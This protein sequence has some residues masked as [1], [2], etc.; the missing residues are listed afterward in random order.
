MFGG[1]ILVSEAEEFENDAAYEGHLAHLRSQLVEAK[2]S[3]LTGE[4]SEGVFR[5][6]VR[7][8]QKRMRELGVEIQVG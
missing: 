6:R 1:D 5:A 8:I 7:V 4:I 2:Y 3:L